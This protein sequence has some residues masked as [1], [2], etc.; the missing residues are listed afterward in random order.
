MLCSLFTCCGTNAFWMTS[1]NS[2]LV[3]KYCGCL[4]IEVAAGMF[5]WP[6]GSTPSTY[7]PAS[8]LQITLRGYR[9]IILHPSLRTS[10]V[11]RRDKFPNEWRT[12]WNNSL[13]QQSSYSFWKKPKGDYRSVH[14]LYE[15][16]WVM[17]TKSFLTT[18]S[19]VEC[20]WRYMETMGDV[21]C[22]W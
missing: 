1:S 5:S 6:V 17:Y 19:V 13:L 11:L 3:A 12:K 15:P 4:N 16:W 21:S 20:R 10:I 18:R 2:S 14:V 7:S 9:R 22:S 8:C